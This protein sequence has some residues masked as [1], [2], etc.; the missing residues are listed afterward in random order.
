MLDISVWSR[1]YRICDAELLRGQVTTLKRHVQYGLLQRAFIHYLRSWTE[2]P[3]RTI[4]YSASIEPYIVLSI[5]SEIID[6]QTS[7]GHTRD[8]FT[9]A[10]Q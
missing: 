2:L 8:Q 5:Q 9:S 10:F 7:G 1:G 6:Y 3:F 4:P